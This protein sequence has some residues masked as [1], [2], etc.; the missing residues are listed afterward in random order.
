MP[1]TYTGV[2]KEVGGAELGKTGN[3]KP[4]K[5]V[6]SDSPD[7]Q[8]KTFRVWSSDST[9]EVLS[10]ALGQQITVQFE[11]EQRQGPQGPYTQNRIVGVQNG[12]GGEGN[13][14]SAVWGS[15]TPAPAPTP[16][17]DW[18]VP[19]SGGAPQQP[20]SPVT[21]DDYW[22]QRQVMDQQRSLEMEAAWAVKSVLDRIP[23]DV[24]YEPENVVT[25]AIAL[26]MLKRRVASELAE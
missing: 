7:Y 13:G 8:G 12:G 19:G 21:K 18:S 14:S 16:S 6:I 24:T 22:E 5:I 2:V 23:Q 11:A 20:P 4:R 17:T 1:E 3:E 9:F 15:A 10:Q 25:A 26:A